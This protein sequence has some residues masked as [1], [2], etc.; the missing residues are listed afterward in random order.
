MASRLQLNEYKPLIQVFCWAE[1]S[2]DGVYQY[3]SS[4]ITCQEQM[5]ENIHSH[6]FV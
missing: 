6:T 4:V 2:D 1:E 3:H 5:G